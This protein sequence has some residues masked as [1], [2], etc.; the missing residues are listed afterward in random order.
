MVD[1]DQYDIPLS[2]LEAQVLGWVDEAISLR[3]GTVGDP[4]NRK[5]R[6]YDPQS[7]HEWVDYIRVVLAR[8]DRIDELR[9]ACTRARHRAKRA[10][11]EATFVAENALDE[12]TAKRAARRVDFETGKERES[13]AKLDSFEKRREAHQTAR[14]V[15]V[16]T[17]AHTVI[18]D[19]YWQLDA[20]RKDARALLHALQFEASLDR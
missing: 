12:A 20:M 17:E 16:T 10:Q 14:L 6:D 13:Q 18:S 15:D 11:S 1:I 8:A 19:I 7:P 2:K 9:T 3:H 5:L 4:H